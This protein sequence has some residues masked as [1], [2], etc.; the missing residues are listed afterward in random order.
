MEENLPPHL[1]VAAGVTEEE[2]ARV[3]RQSRIVAFTSVASGIVIAT[4]LLFFFFFLIA[5]IAGALAGVAAERLM[6]MS[7]KDAHKAKTLRIKMYP[8]LRSF[9][10]TKI[11][12]PE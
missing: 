11:S 8:E 9:R 2:Y 6:N 5:A 10:A 4:L 3:I 1:K 12:P 7:L